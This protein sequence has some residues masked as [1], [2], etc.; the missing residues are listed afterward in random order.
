MGL[1]VGK[2][3]Q[4]RTGFSLAVSR[5]ETRIRTKMQVRDGING[6]VHMSCVPVYPS[7]RRP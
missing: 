3:K 1:G 7:G 6:A 4:A 5:E 2:P